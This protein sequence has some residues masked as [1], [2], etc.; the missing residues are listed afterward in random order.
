M[1][2]CD[3]NSMVSLA[4][5]Q[6]AKFG[7]YIN[8]SLTYQDDDSDIWNYVLERVTDLNTRCNLVNGGLFLFDSEIEAADFY[9]IFGSGPVYAS[10]IYALLLDSNG[11]MIT[12]NT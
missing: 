4:A 6:S 2:Y 3:W 11:E 7:V 12:E 5:K 9:R 1:K 8:N 10:G